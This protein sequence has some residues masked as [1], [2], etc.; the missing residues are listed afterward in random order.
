M[1]NYENKAGD[2]KFPEDI[3]RTKQREKI[4]RIL[5]C[6][7]KPMSAADI[8]QCI[9]KSGVNTWFAISTV[10]RVLSVFEKK[11]S[12]LP[13]INWNYM[14]FVKAAKAKTAVLSTGNVFRIISFVSFFSIIQCMVCLMKQN[15]YIGNRAARTGESGRCLDRLY[16]TAGQFYFFIFQ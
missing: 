6:A 5:F 7:S 3:K 14:V 1:E 10:Y 16:L 9:L 4:F 11:G 13:G 2:A 15:R 8:Y 12:A